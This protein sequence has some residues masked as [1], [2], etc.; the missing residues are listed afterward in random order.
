MNKNANYTWKLGLFVILGLIILIIGIYVVGENQNLFGS[1]FRLKTSFKNVSGLKEGNNVRFSGIVVGTVKEIEFVSDSLVVV[2]MV[3]EADV[4]KYIKK[5]ATAN[6]G[7]DGL[8]GDKVLTIIPGKTSNKQ[9]EDEDTIGSTATVEMEELMKG[10]SKTINNAETIS[11]E[12]S[13]FSKKINTLT[14]E[15]FAKNIQGTVSNLKTTSDQFAVFTTNMNN[16]NGLLSKLTTDERLGRSFDST[17]TNIQTGTQKI[18]EIGDAAKNNFLLRGYFKKKEK[19]EAK[20]VKD[21]LKELEKN[22]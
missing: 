20:K 19:A 15:E 9:V 1:T 7:S 14:D 22:R 17:M 16:K 8:M 13:L 11:K 4:Q 6:I 5:D 2:N 12:L 21:S 10:L 18:N 3:I